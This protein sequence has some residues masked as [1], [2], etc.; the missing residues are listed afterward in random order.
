[1]PIVPI[2][3]IIAH[4][5]PSHYCPLLPIV[6]ITAHYR[7]SVMHMHRPLLVACPAQTKSQPSSQFGLWLMT[8]CDVLELLGQGAACGMRHRMRQWAMAP[9]S[10]AHAL[11]SVEARG[12]GRI[13][14]ATTGHHTRV[15]FNLQKRSACSIK[16]LKITLM[17]IGSSFYRSSSDID[18]VHVVFTRKPLCTVA[19]S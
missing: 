7:L 8:R 14:F 1:M 9:G 18:P 13:A 2:V 6:P 15:I 11:W 12:E 17:I 4:Y 5:C 10:A 3:P 16:S 19:D